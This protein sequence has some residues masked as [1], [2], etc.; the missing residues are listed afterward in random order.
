MHWAISG[1]KLKNLKSHHSQPVREG[2]NL[3]LVT[4]E[5]SLR[6]TPDSGEARQVIDEGPTFQPGHLRR[7]HGSITQPQKTHTEFFVFWVPE[8]I[9]H[10]YRAFYLCHTFGSN[11][12]LPQDH[13]PLSRIYRANLPLY[14]PQISCSLNFKGF[15]GG[16]S[17]FLL[18]KAI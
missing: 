6:N 16:S 11:K 7:P 15:M 8:R 12:N 4:S 10:P 5:D 1:R 17:H 9:K 18:S 3:T 2:V 13:R 14:L